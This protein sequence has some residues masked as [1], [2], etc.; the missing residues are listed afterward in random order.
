MS[1]ETGGLF[2][3]ASRVRWTNDPSWADG[4]CKAVLFLEVSGIVRILFLEIVFI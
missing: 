1:G 3:R 2:Q 4:G